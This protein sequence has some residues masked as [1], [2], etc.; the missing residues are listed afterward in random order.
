MG[1]A[2]FTDQEFDFIHKFQSAVKE[3]KLIGL[4]CKDCG[5]T[6]TIPVVYCLKC[7]SPNLEIVE[8]PTTGKIITFS[9]LPMVVPERFA[10]EAP[11]A[12]AVIELDDGTRVSGWIPYVRSEKDLK[13]GQKVK[14]VRAG[15]KPGMVFK[16]VEE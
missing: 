8:L 16:K 11:Y 12:W 14:L 3:G 6:H 1:K 2:G 4:K 9:V 15:F 7:Q 10:E 13:I 5:H